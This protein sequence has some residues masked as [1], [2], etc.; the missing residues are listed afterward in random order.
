MVCDGHEGRWGQVCSTDVRRYLCVF[1]ALLLFPPSITVHNMIDPNS[2]YMPIE[3]RNYTPPPHS[4]HTHT[5]APNTASQP[6][7]LT[8]YP[9]CE[10]AFNSDPT[11]IPAFLPCHCPATMNPAL[12]MRPLSISA[13]RNLSRPVCGRSR[14]SRSNSTSPLKIGCARREGSASNDALSRILGKWSDA[15]GDLRCGFANSFAGVG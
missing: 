10:S 12:T 11:L 14:I 6:N 13:G 15:I 7:A 5:T 8:A 2:K 1:L 4:K 9:P 3:K